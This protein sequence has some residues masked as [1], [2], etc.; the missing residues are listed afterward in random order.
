MKSTKKGGLVLY[1]QV[2]VTT[3]NSIVWVTT[4]NSIV[5]VSVGDLCVHELRI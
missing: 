1:L 3:T 4:T 5:W 2:V